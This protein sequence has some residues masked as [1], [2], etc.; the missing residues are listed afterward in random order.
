MP[1]ASFDTVSGFGP[2]DEVRPKIRGESPPEEEPSNDTASSSE[3]DPGSP[4]A[5]K[6][7]QEKQEGRQDEQEKHR[8][9]GISHEELEESEELP[10]E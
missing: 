2:V 3:V 4:K 1:S 6:E 8:D 7:R 10:E 5:I 9:A